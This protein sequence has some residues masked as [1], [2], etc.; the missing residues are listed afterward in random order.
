MMTL[1]DYY[2]AIIWTAQMEIKYMW[3]LEIYEDL[4]VQIGEFNQCW[5]EFHLAYV[6]E[7]SL[8]WEWVTSLSTL[9]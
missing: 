3:L 5:C 2:A 8:A 9:P 1:S 6:Y 4:P 7:Y